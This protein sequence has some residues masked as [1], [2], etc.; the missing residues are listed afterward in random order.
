M[1]P[2][3]VLNSLV[4]LLAFVVGGKFADVDLAPVFPL[5][6]RSAWTHGPLV[7]AL[8]WW[9]STLH[10]LGW[11]VAVGFLPAYALHLLADL[12]PKAWV[13]SALIKLYPLPLSFNPALSFLWIALGVVAAWW[14]WW[15]PLEILTIIQRWL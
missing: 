5:R 6:H 9:V 1:I 13:G 4:A 2:P 12:W 14:V 15:Y 8:V 3:W 11:Y 10:P 7:P